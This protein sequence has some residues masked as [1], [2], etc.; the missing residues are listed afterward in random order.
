[1]KTAF[2]GTSNRRTAPCPYPR[3][4]CMAYRTCSDACSDV[5]SHLLFRG[6]DAHFIKG[7]GNGNDSDEDNDCNEDATSD[8]GS[9]TD[10]VSSLILD[11]QIW[12]D[13]KNQMFQSPI[14]YSPVSTVSEHERDRS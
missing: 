11:G 12:Q 1:M 8:G 4:C 7:E 9:I 3:R 13:W 2:E 6:F 10:L 14:S 5:Q